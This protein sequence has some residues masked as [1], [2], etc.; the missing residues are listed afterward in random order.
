MLLDIEN[1]QGAQALKNKRYDDAERFLRSALQRA[2]TLQATYLEASILVNLGMIRLKR[3][4]YDE[5]AGFFEEASRRA[6]R[7][8]KA[9]ADDEPKIA[10]GA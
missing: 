8:L 2:R 10:I 5:A 7:E 6:L 1:L 9:K 4:R 3:H